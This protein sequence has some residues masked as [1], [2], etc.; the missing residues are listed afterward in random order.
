[1]GRSKS[2]YLSEALG[3]PCSERDR[4]EPRGARFHFGTGTHY[5]NRLRNRA[6]IADFPSE[7]L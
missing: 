5:R 3:T 2:H 1:M 7:F 6:C 4:S